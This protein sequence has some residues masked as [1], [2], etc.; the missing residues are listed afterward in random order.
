MPMGISRRAIRRLR[1]FIDLEVERQR[2]R[3]ETDPAANFVS[4]QCWKR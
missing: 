3:L 1:R 4:R 2:S